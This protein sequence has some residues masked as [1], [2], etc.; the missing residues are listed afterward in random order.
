MPRNE[1]QELRE[2]LREQMLV[3]F[4][5]GG[6]TPSRIADA[7]IRDHKDLVDRLADGLSRSALLHMARQELRK[8]EAN[9]HAARTQIELPIELQKRKLP[10]I[11]SVPYETADDEDSDGDDDEDSVIWIPWRQA[12]LAQALGHL[13]LLNDSIARDIARRNIW[14]NFCDFWLQ[15][16]D[17]DLDAVI[18]DLIDESQSEPAP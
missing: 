16:A 9:G 2:K 7:V 10:A 18:G 13:N 4:T 6:A 14:K 8:A 1:R 15:K 3:A 5:G 17:G 11:I 12:T